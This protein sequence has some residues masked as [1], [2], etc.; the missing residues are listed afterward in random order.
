MVRSS[1]A[2]STST[3]ILAGLAISTMVSRES[4]CPSS[5]PRLRHQIDHGRLVIDG[6]REF[7][8]RFDHHHLDAD[9]AHGVIV[10]I[11]RV[12]GGDDL[13]LVHARQI[14]DADQLFGIA[15][16]H[17]GRGDVFQARRAAGRDHAPLCAGDLGQPPPHAL[18]QLIV[19]YKVARR[20]PLPP[21]A[22]PDAVPTRR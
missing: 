18:G 19:L 15:A 4:G 10:G 21:P 17:T 12:S 20:L 11:A 13:R 14:G 3:G 7:G 2:A 22:L 8:R 5:D 16:G 1:A 9:V 6:A